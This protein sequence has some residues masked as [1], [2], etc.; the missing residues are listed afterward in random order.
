[1]FLQFLFDRVVT[2]S[3]LSTFPYNNYCSYHDSCQDAREFSGLHLPKKGESKDNERAC[4]KIML[5]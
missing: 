2:F 5:F 3:V 4:V 1:M